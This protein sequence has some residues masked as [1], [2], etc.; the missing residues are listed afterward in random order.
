M[1]LVK[2]QKNSKIKKMLK[3]TKI[4]DLK[5]YYRS[6]DRFI[7]QRIAL[8]KYEKYETALLLSQINKNS[9]CVD[10]GANIGYYTLLM[11]RLAKKVYAFEPDKKSFGILKKNVE[12]NGLKNVVLANI[13]VSN[14]RGK[15][16]LVRDKD[17]FGNSRINDKNGEVIFTDSLDNILINEQKISLIKIDTQGHEPEVI[18]GAKKIIKSSRPILF[19]EYTPREYKDKKMINFLKKIY[20]NIFSI[21]DFAEAPWP[22]RKGVKVDKHG[23]SDLFLKEKMRIVD[24]WTM[25]KNVNYRK[26]LKGIMNYG[27]NKT[28]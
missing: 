11:A 17:N 20:D 22:I 18:G 14:K 24:Y 27:K 13:G 7:G 1:K 2:R 23:Y 10:V 3:L 9:I 19:L 25:L 28:H 5:F 26:W 12:E 15:K 16:Y 6:N 8:D 21:S 4:D